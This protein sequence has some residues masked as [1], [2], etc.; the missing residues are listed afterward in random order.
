MDTEEYA[1]LFDRSL[2][3]LHE[4]IRSTPDDKLWNIPNGISNSAGVLAKHLIGNLNHYIGYG[5]GNT[6]YNRTR[7]F[8][9]RKSGVLKEE[10][11]SQVI[12][13]RQMI[14]SVLN[15]LAEDDLNRKYPVE[16]PYDYTIEQ[17]LMHLHSH[18]NYHMGQLN[19][20]RRILSEE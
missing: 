12:D 19:Y 20:L 16:I 8:E 9:F 4:N 3:Q 13:L 7:A 10:L 17:F 6:G 14:R 18:L 11:L 15:Q 2:E 1:E 5:L